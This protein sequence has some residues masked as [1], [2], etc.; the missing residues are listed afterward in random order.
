MNYLVSA[1]NTC[2]QHWQ[3]EL[4]I[5]SFKLKGLQDRLLIGLAHNDEDKYLDYTVNLKHANAFIHEN[6]G[7][8]LDLI[9]AN[10]PYAVY[11]AQL[12][13]LLKQPFALISPDMVMIEPVKPGKEQITFQ[14]NPAFTSAGVDEQFHDL[15]KVKEIEPFWFPVGA[16]MVFN[17]VPLDFFLR[18]IQWCQL[19]GKNEKAA[20]A[21][22]F[23]EYYGHMTYEG[24]H[25]Y[26]VSLL[27]YVPRHNFIHYKHGMPPYF[28]KY[29]Y[30]YRPPEV[31]SMGDPFEDI[32]QNNPT[33]V[34]N[35]MQDVVRSYCKKRPRRN[36]MISKIQKVTVKKG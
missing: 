18:V 29:L 30:R 11:A 19:L 34:S 16:V 5:E 31:L 20:W 33:P 35:I 24:T 28:N 32:L 14:I 26:E 6:F 12:Q 1:E 27:D 21:L 17:D 2:Y 23:F 36:E 7:Q 10:R 3:L 8:S 9:E 13:G 4:L 15:A 25:G 22:T